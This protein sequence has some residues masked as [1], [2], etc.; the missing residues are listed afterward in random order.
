MSHGPHALA[1]RTPRKSWLQPLVAASAVPTGLEIIFRFTQRF[2]A[3]Y[4]TRG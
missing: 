2:R 1:S 3:R 4:E